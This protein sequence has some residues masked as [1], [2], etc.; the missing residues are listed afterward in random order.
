MEQSQHNMNFDL[1]QFT[2][3]V[4][5]LFEQQASFATITLV[6]IRGSAPQIVGAK[7]VI[8]DRGIE[9]GT[10]GGGKI[11][12]AAVKHAQQLL[13]QMQT[14]VCEL[15]KWNL[16]TDIGMT[17]GGEV[18]FL[19][20]VVRNECWPIVVFG[21]GHIS[22]QLIPLLL[23]LNCRVTCV[24][25]RPDWIGRL[26]DSR[27]LTKVCVDDMPAQV[28]GQPSGSFFVMMTRGH[29]TDL[30]ILTEV[31][32]TR[33]APFVGVIG[34]KQKASVLRRDLKDQNFSAEKIDSFYCPMGKPIG[35]NTPAEIAV[36]V[37]A[38][39]LE[40]RDQLGL[41]AHKAK[42]F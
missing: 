39:L 33:D 24:D 21:A 27:K 32:A 38:Q 36:S 17:C 35:N 25:P 8:T 6:S 41:F 19:F 18:Q 23:T 13:D 34:S 15:V 42:E 11:E 26:P 40:V 12:A 28:A 5:E 16:Q 1:F 4:S 22:Q 30:P 37:V 3:K 29:A 2:Q 14:N 10:V 7:A 31:L 9:A 20:E